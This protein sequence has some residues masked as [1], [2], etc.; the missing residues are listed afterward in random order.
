MS[1]KRSR[2]KS[3]KKRAAA[4]RRR[5]ARPYWSTWSDDELLDL[6]LCDLDVRIQGTWL[7]DMIGKLYGELER[8][9]IR[10][11]PHCWLSNEWFSPDGVPGIA[12]PFYLAHPRLMQLERRQMLDVEGGTR[13]WCMRILRH[14]AGHALDTAYRLRR[15]RRW[16]KAFGRAGRPYPASYRARPHSKNHVLHLEWWYAQSHPVE[17]FAETF[18]VWL[19]PRG[20]WRRQYAD[21][22]V[23]RKL[24]Y[25]DELMGEIADTPAAVRSRLQVE[26]LRSRKR[27]LRAHYRAKRARYG[28]D[29]P[30]FYDQQLERV[31]RPGKAH[32]EEAASTFLRRERAAIRRRVEEWTG[33]PAYTV[34]QF[35][36]EMIAR[37]RR[38]GLR[39]SRSE[40][41]VKLEAAILL[42]VQVM[43]YVNGGG[44]HISL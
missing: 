21:W 31:F 4:R 42:T 29:L 28:V 1:A 24:E 3:S 25:V 19:D 38:L 17:D 14:E 26:P 13:E 16:Q 41:R 5:P 2:K 11:R 20:A 8:R 44:H 23:L 36:R 43:G 33:Q 9:D 27:S 6:R 7:E 32:T 22:P 10:L 15:K 37:C 18:A 30:D 39:R 12:I 35:L 34:D 40:R